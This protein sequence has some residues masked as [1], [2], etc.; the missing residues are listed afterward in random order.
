M[1]GFA[2][3]VHRPV[4]LEAPL[5]PIVWAVD[6]AP[7]HVAIP[8]E[9]KLGALVV[10]QVPPISTLHLHSQ[11]FRFFVLDVTPSFSEFTADEWS[12][13]FG[14]VRVVRK[15]NLSAFLCHQSKS[16]AQ[17]RM[18]AS[19]GFSGSNGCKYEPASTAVSIALRFHSHC[20]E[21][22]VLS[23]RDYIPAILERP[24]I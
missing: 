24:R 4:F 22:K 5:A 13:A 2:A 16:L 1:R 12:L 15:Q 21:R 23:R 19:Y 18:T 8:S 3:L 17:S 20:S 9:A 6:G 7:F 14:R 11:D 10:F